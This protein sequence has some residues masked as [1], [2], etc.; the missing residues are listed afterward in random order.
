MS[1]TFT[2]GA[3]TFTNGSKTVSGVTLAQGTLNKFAPG[4]RVVVGVNPVI[5][6]VGANK[7]LSADSFELDIAWELPTGTY[8]FFANMTSEGLWSAVQQIRGNAQALQAYESGFNELLTSTASSVNIN[9]VDVVPFGYLVQQGQASIDTFINN[10]QTRLDR[11][12]AMEKLERDAVFLGKFT[13]DRVVKS[14]GLSK[15]ATS[16]ADGITYTSP[17]GVTG[18]AADGTIQTAGVNQPPIVYDPETGECLGLQS[19]PAGTAL[20]LF[21][22][23]L[24]RGVWS[25][26]SGIS[27]SISSDTSPIKGGDT[28][29]TVSASETNN[30]GYVYQAAEG[31][32]E[33]EVYSTTSVLRL[34]NI[35]ESDLRVA[36]YDQTNS[37]FITEDS[38]KKIEKLA[39]GYIKVTSSVACPAGCTSMRF[40]IHR[41]LMNAGDVM[42]HAG[43]DFK[44]GYPAPY[45]GTE[46]SQLTRDSSFFR[47]NAQGNVNT[48]GMTFYIDCYLNPDDFSGEYLVVGDDSSRRFFYT[49]IVANKLNLRTY[50][51]SNTTAIPVVDNR[52]RACVVVRPNEVRLFYNGES[53]SAQHNGNLL[54]P[55]SKF[56]F[57]ERKASLTVFRD[58]IAAPVLLSDAEAIALTTPEQ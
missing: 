55:V 28:P 24:T 27:Y 11:L 7:Q 6:E 57:N 47:A 54:Q 3:A 49:Y 45:I 23:D 46:A 2:L 56:I 19:T 18:I 8:S 25:R 29:Q 12:R 20:S 53:D 17:D 34:L 51:G 36:Y 41:G 48:N 9:G 38:D 40:Y 22:Q 14:V 44:R 37:A 30:T 42:N 4:T 31:L 5:N 1:N 39:G 58:F 33:G 26:S 50:D 52:V 35:T 32:S 21:S 13:E 10:N 15:V 43:T 16:V